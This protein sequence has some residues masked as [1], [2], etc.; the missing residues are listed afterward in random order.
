MNFLVVAD[1]FIK[2]HRVNVATKKVN[3]ILNC[4]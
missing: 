1:K 4:K 2:Y 3:M